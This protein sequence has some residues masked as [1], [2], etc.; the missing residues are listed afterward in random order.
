MSEAIGQLL[1]K[2]R[3][4]LEQ[5]IAALASPWPRFT[6]FL[7]FSDGHR[8][9]SVVH[10]SGAD[11]DAVWQEL[12][13]ACQRRAARRTL[14][15]RWLRAD[16]V[17][18]AQSL[19][20]QGLKTSLKVF[21]RNYFRYGLALDANFQRA[22][23]EG[24][25][26]GNAMLYGG[27]QVSHAQLNEKNFRLYA[28][29]RYPR[30][31]P[32][33]AD[34]A[35]VY[36]LSTE[37][38]FCDLDT[39]PLAL[40]ATGYDAGRRV[41]DCDADTVRGMIERSSNYLAS[42]VRESG[43]FHYG[44]HPC[45]DRPINAYNTLRHASTLY[46]MLE[47]WEVTREPSLA[48]AIE[49]GLDYLCT[50]LIKRVALPS[51][52]RAAFLLDVGDEIKLGGN[53]VCLLALVKYSE[54]FES[55]QYLTLLEELALGIRHM[56]DPGTGEFVHVLNYPA[57]DVKAAFRIIY[58][59]GEAAF[60]LMRLYRLTG[61]AR[62]LAMVEKAFDSFIAREHWKAHDHW[63][64]YC[65]NELTLYRPEERYF[66]FGIRN[67]AD[68]LDF[69]LKRITTFPTLL[70]LMMAARRMLER[71]AQ[72]PEHRHLLGEIDLDE[73]DRALHHRAAYLMN[74]HF[75]PEYAMYFRNPA[76]ILGSFFIRHQA[77]RV[78]IDDVEHYLSGY[79]AYWKLLTELDPVPLLTAEPGLDAPRKP[80]GPV[81][82]WGG[83]INLG[84]RQHYRTAELGSG[85]VLRIPALTEA[86]LSII[87][88]EC[89]V[90]RQGEQG[91]NK[92]EGGPYYYRARPEQLQVLIDANIDVVT[93]ANNHSGD[94]GR[95]ALQEQAAWLDA[96]GLGH[97]GSG[98]QREAAFTPVLRR[99]GDLNVAVF[100]IDA[101]QHRYAAD[102]AN[103][104]TAY[105]D[106]N[107]A[108]AWAAEMAPRIAAIRQRAHIVL[109][110]VHW[111]DNLAKAPSAAQTAVGHSLIDAG[112]DAVL[113][114]SAH[115]L[116]G[117][118]IYRERPIIHDAGDLLF[119]SVR[120][121]LGRSGVFRLELSH[122]GV[123]R[124]IFVP[125]GVGFGFSEQL[126][127]R[128]ARAAVQA[129]ARSCAAT[130]SRLT[131]TKDH[132]GQITL[133]PPQ[134]R[135]EWKVPAPCTVHQ[136]GALVAV[137]DPEPGWTTDAVPVD[138]RIEP[139]QLG[140]LTLLG[141]RI[142]P[143]TMDRRR[144][145]WVE[146]FWRCDEPVEEDIRLDF[147]AVPMSATRMKPWGISMDHDPCD[148]MMP[149]S[150]WQPG[151]IYRDY[152]GLR[153]PYLKDWENVDLQ[154]VANIV[155]RQQAS[156]PVPL[157]LV[158]KL[159]VPGKDQ[160]TAPLPRTSPGNKPRYSFSSS[161]LA[162]L[163]NGAWAYPPAEEVYIDYFVTGAG[164]VEQPGTCMVCMFYDTWLKGTG[165]TGH[166]KNI[167]TDSHV[168]FLNRYKKLD[169]EGKV[170]CLIVQRPIPE[171]SHIPQLVVEDS[172]QILKTLATAARNKMGDNGTVFAVT[173]AVGKSTTCELLARA[174]RPFSNCVA[175]NN[176]HNSRTGV[177]IQAAS[178]GLFSPAFNEQDSLPNTCVLEVAGSALWMKNGWVMKAVRP[179]IGIITHVE[180]TQYGA[181]SRTIEDV[182]YFK[183]RICEAIYPDGMA[184]LYREM[185]HYE[186]VLEHV[187]GYGAKPYS[188]GESEGVD[189]RLLSWD[190]NIP[191]IDHQQANLTM[192]V[193]AEVLGEKVVY[194]V[195]AI[196]KPVALNSL[197]ALTA[198]RLAG[199]DIQSAAK[200]FAEFKARKNTLD[201][202]VHADVLIVDCS[203]N[204]E[205][206]SILAAFDV[207]KASNFS[208]GGRRFVIMSRIVN[209]GDIAAA[210]HL[211][212]EEPFKEYGFDKFF[213]HNPD[214]EWDQLLPRLPSA[215][216]GGVSVDAAGT[217]SQFMSHVR[218]GDTVLLLGASRGC[219]FGEVLP[220]I[221]ERL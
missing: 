111:G 164:L 98:A 55:E 198:A 184:V 10:A 92:G 2:M 52:E 59:D 170:N 99:A 70:E 102:D 43:R 134:R 53:A 157:P 11:L 106:L 4:V 171:L 180:L 113:G 206:P 189:A 110:A 67:V 139:R 60:G 50:E 167:F 68:H 37:G 188:Y 199:F 72:S 117:I 47:A 166:Y 66:R 214:H 121:D 33:F 100:S 132:C 191:T 82:V 20:W 192:T 153:P 34:D 22:F 194:D 84:R 185:P 96:V 175:I 129:Y 101:T 40:H 89:V 86:D 165:N 128:A 25:L 76:R 145:L 91:V 23:L 9:A 148:W 105:L 151:V 209:M 115:V 42:Q 150:R 27:S 202:S 169:L 26:N 3:P 160:T 35:P 162:R 56:Q 81:V 39:P 149:T 213:I 95:D 126:S 219:D 31:V 177:L 137:N 182:A 207:L 88:L 104:G 146:S 120:R 5:R 32:D 212:L 62:W 138:A 168:S 114:A 8:R 44:W 14:Q 133:T 45:F 79:V 187:Q 186:K 12:Y 15:V 141:C 190:F 77:F 107:D 46:S 220:A 41:L 158:L 73:F 7:S 13:T 83:D 210:F 63:L 195:G 28:S 208:Q 17:T 85:N 69:V 57:L 16:W 172:Y 173:G 136:P 118:E 159:A 80:S 154:L 216:I 221:L 125:I 54:L 193:T 109:V 204:L 143:T 103:P 131:L 140:P 176:G 161:E 116:Q 49:R 71:I 155:S 201:V 119:D 19:N 74:G 130:G 108:A 135:H 181:A 215:L 97:T 205:I 124:V 21:K 142:T 217:V 18:Q 38:L 65:V 75:W 48:Q 112:A 200:E 211:R 218:K 127:G 93:T 24:E 196:G 123:E 122:Q 87:N 1:D 90:A 179:N 64:G 147:C 163:I 51:G 152:Y 144:M 156:E 29:R 61:D 94:Y 178:L 58:Y 174:V 203:H 6:L 30:L 197:A 36:L 78:R 183:S